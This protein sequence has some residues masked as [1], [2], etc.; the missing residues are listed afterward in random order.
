MSGKRRTGVLALLLPG[1]VGGIT[2]IYLAKPRLERE[3]GALQ[4]SAVQARD[5]R[6]SAADLSRAVAQERRL[7]EEI[8]TLEAARTG[9]A[10]SAGAGSG[11][12][13]AVLFARHRIL[14]LEETL[15][16]PAPGSL[17]ET[18][19]KAAPGRLR[20]LSLAGRYL[21][22]LSAL[23]GLVDPAIGGVPLRLV[24]SRENGDVQWTLLLWM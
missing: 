2:Y 22:I 1:L 24:M 19:A 9:G 17:P 3:L 13:L 23:S 12:H 11:E 7:Q 15:D 20:R 8:R 18:F 4:V 5:R 14:V 10:P 16:P 6:P 21:D